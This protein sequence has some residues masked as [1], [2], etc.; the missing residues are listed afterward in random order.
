MPRRKT[1]PVFGLGCEHW[2]QGEYQ[3]GTLGRGEMAP[4]QV[5]RQHTIKGRALAVP[6]LEYWLDTGHKTCDE[7]I[8]AFENGG[9][10]SDNCFL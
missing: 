9:V 1:L 6:L 8:A 7:A 4:M 3:D 10:K 5:L 2:Q